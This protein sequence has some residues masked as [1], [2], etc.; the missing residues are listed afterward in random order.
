MTPAR[1]T[2]AQSRLEVDNMGFRW[3]FEWWAGCSPWLRFG[4]AGVFLLIAAIMLVFGRF[5]ILGWAV[6]GVLLVFAFPSKAERRGY[7]DF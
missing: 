1:N 2:V 4:V 7:H 6:G 3:L 5:W